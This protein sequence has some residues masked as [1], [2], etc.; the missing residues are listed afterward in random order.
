MH[1]YRRFKS[2]FHSCFFQLVATAIL[3]SPLTFSIF[4]EGF[5]QGEL[6]DCSNLVSV[7]HQIYGR[8]SE[9][10]IL[11]PGF[12]L[13]S[14]GSNLLFATKLWPPILEAKM[15]INSKQVSVILPFAAAP[16]VATVLRASF[17]IIDS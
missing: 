8:S 5:L 3:P 16:R 15:I 1:S 12:E 6:R 10:C 7:F 2:L 9:Q 4:L 11:V 14:K 17:I 13:A